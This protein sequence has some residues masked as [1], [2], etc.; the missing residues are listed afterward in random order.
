MRPGRGRIVVVAAVAA[1]AAAA[2][3]GARPDAKPKPAATTATGIWL[4]ARELKALPT[5]GTA[6]RSVL[7]V[8]EGP[9]GTANVADQ[10]SNH[11][12]RTL[13]V[14]LAAARTGRADLRAKATSALLSAVGTEANARWLAVG[15]NV[16]AYAIAA[17]ILGLRADRNRAS[18]GSR[19]HA[20][21][22]GF[23]TR[24]LRNNIS[25][26]PTTLRKSAWSSGSNAS[27]QEGF[28]HAAVAAYLGN[29]KELDWAWNGFRRYAGDRTSPHKL[30]ANDPSWQL[31]PSDPV[32]IQNAGAEKEGCR[33][34]GA[35]SNDMARG[36]KFRCQPRYTQ[37]PWVGLEG[38]VPAAVI[39][40]RQGYPAWNVADRALYRAF[41]YLWFLR[42][43]AERNPE[44][45]FDGKRSRDT[46][47]LANRAYGST[48]IAA[49][50]VG[51]GRTVGFT[52]W[53][54]GPDGA[55][56]SRPRTRL[57]KID[58]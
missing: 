50:P 20:W 28:V 34:D 55:V 13:A 19:V 15:R 38:V 14:A 40:A 39:L 44:R 33:L 26:A 17:D 48:F 51:E 24:S 31:Q 42:T 11:D 32:G 6:W 21:L 12:V 23:L 30:T 4:T 57:A 7:S 56:V 8:A 58:P 3:A 36:S 45:W 18:A 2:V 53:T 5:R 41:D 46:I 54:H 1:L 16:G 29:R 52:D 35:I 9:L 43:Q 10:N 25:A 27:A 22:A 47:V 49:L 37:Y